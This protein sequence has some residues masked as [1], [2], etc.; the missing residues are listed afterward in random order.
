MEML[1]KI[2]NGVQ[3]CILAAAISFP[4]YSCSETPEHRQ[5]CQ[6]IVQTCKESKLDYDFAFDHCS[7]GSK[8]RVFV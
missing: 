8:I 1:Q 7:N 3:Y 2:K 6:E 5:C 4:F